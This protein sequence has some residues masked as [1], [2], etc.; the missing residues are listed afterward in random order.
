MFI[1]WFKNVDNEKNISSFANV[2]LESH[3]RKYFTEIGCFFHA[4]LVQYPDPINIKNLP[5]DLKDEITNNVLNIN[6]DKSWNHS[7]WRKEKNVHKQIA[8]IKEWSD[9]VIKYMNSDRNS[10][11]MLSKETISYVDRMDKF[12]GQSFREVYP[13]YGRYI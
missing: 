3:S 9:Y 13:E 4:S 6:L 2:L 10:I 11:Q 12:N 7:I 5:K 1:N 8:R